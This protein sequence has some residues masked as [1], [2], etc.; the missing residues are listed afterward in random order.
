MGQHEW[1]KERHREAGRYLAALIGC[2]LNDKKAPEKPEHI[3][4]ETVYS[5][6]ERNSVTGVSW[7]GVDTLDAPPPEELYRRWKENVNRTLYRQLHFDEE[8]QQILC[9]M[10][11]KGL[12]Y[13]PLKG[14][15]IAGYYPKPGMRSMADNDILYGFVEVSPEGGY[16]IRG[17]N[18]DE[19]EE[20]IREAQQVMVSIMRERGYEV[21]S[22]KGNHD[23]YLKK[24]FYNFEMHRSL[25]SRNS[26]HY[27]YYANPWKRAVKSSGDPYLYSFSDEDEYLFFLV[28]AFKHFDNNGCGI[29]SL[30]DLYVFLKVKG[31]RMDMS[32]IRAELETLQMTEFVEQMKNLGNAVFEGGRAMTP[33]EE[34]LLYYL[35]GCGTYGTMRAGIERKIEKLAESG[36]I[37]ARQAKM[38]YF[39]QRFFVS[40][41]K[42][43]EHFPFFY[44][45]RYLRPFLM[46]YRVIRGLIVHPGKLWKEAKIVLKKK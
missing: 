9:K 21:E 16:Q 38:K 45:H 37:G 10:Q 19:Q 15:H 5:L 43:R 42:C 22:L 27:F 26:P 46:P 14:I 8:R 41:D 13:L 1:M 44:R 18:E 36:T 30:A 29:R 20:S 34:E 6:A 33:E 28:H 23:V 35:L 2:A 7:Y 31:D 40:E 24:P 39:S 4:W 3:D 12:S 11:A 25:A 17:R 32:Y